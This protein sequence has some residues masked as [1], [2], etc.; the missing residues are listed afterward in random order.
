MKVI[1]KSHLAVHCFAELISTLRE[2]HRSQSYSTAESFCFYGHRRYGGSD[3]LRMSQQPF[4]G[5]FPDAGSGAAAA[6]AA[7][8]A[9]VEQYICLVGLKL[10]F[11]Y[12]THTVGGERK[13]NLRHNWKRQNTAN[14]KCII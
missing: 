9:L 10:V 4:S 8:A 5:L 1:C 14:Y 11:R 3:W 2:V 12:W 13:S 7:V 6:T